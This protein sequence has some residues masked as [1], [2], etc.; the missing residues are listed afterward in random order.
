MT[1][2]EEELK[3]LHTALS[4]AEEKLKDGGIPENDFGKLR[5]QVETNNCWREGSVFYPDYDGIGYG[6]KVWN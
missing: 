2:S 3:I 6:V 1:F 5:Y 4:M